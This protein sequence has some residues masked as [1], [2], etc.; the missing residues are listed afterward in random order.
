[1]KV[2][3]IALVV[4]LACVA[5]M[6]YSNSV[7]AQVKNGFHDD[8]IL[9]DIKLDNGQWLLKPTSVIKKEAKDYSAVFAAK[10]ND[11]INGYVTYSTCFDILLFILLCLIDF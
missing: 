9:S 3:V 8:V 4:L 6:V 5:H 10:G 2:I 11:R 1:M 7:T